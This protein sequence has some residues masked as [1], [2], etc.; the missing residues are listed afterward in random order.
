MLSKIS[1]IS[2]AIGAKKKAKR[3]G[4]TLACLAMLTMATMKGSEK[5]PMSA[6]PTIRYPTPAQVV[7]VSESLLSSESEMVP[8]SGSFFSGF[9]LDLVN[10]HNTKETY[11]KTPITAK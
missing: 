8:N 2:E 6:P 4:F 1:G 9:F 10:S 3:M 7:L 5:I 11:K